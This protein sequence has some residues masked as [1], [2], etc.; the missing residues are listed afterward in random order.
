[1]SV[2]YCRCYW[3]E[4]LKIRFSLRGTIDLHIRTVSR[5]PYTF[6]LYSY[7]VPYTIRLIRKNTIDYLS[8]WW[9]KTFSAFCITPSFVFIIFITSVADLRREGDWRIVSLLGAFCSIYF[10]LY[11]S[12]SYT[13]YIG[14]KKSHI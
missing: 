6:S 10:V 9:T 7:N 2:G 12:V 11:I 14:K 1:M 13:D 4:N 3:F 5:C 8:C